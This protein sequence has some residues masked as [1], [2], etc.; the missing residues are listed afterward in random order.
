MGAQLEQYFTSKLCYQH[1]EVLESFVVSIKQK[2]PQAVTGVVFYGSC[3]RTHEY[4]DGMLDFYVIVDRYTH[5]Y[6]SYWYR[7]ANVLMPPNVFYLQI[8]VAGK[9]YHA[10]YAVM[11]QT[12]LM[13]RVRQDFHCYFWARFT[14]PMA[15]IFSRD[16][17]FMS[18][19][20]KVQCVAAEKFYHSVTPSL[21]NTLASRDFWIKGLQLTY[22][23]ELRAETQSRATL[24]YENDSEYYDAIYSYITP[25]TNLSNT[26]LLFYQ[27][28]WKLRIVYGKLLS[29]IRLMKATTTF[30]GGVDY[31]AWKIERHTGEAIFISDKMRKYPW[32]YIWPVVFKLFKQGKIH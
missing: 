11:S 21:K 23:A 10:K 19:F 28:Q 16:K 1:D 13:R 8:D 15:Y 7:L 12:S 31:I 5:A 17:E 4:K 9:T 27:M 6:K 14:Q 18:W 32:L 3:M 25:A 20:V 30:D 22:A 29:V 24:I 2:H 26:R